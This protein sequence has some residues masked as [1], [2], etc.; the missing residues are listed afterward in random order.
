MPHFPFFTFKSRAKMAHFQLLLITNDLLLDSLLI[1]FHSYIPFSSERG[2]ILSL[3]HRI[4]NICPNY[5]NFHQELETFKKMYRLN[6]YP[7]N[8]FGDCVSVLFHKVFSANHLVHIA[9]KKGLY[10]CL[11]FT[12]IRL[13]QICKQISTVFSTDFSHLNIRFIFRPTRRP[14]HFLP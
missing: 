5:E 13:F 8:L 12:G 2:L 4:F 9:P 7:T 11:A 14:S 1:N 3:L 6:G 10:L